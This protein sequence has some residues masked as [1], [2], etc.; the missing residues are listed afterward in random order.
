MLGSMTDLQNTPTPETTTDDSLEVQQRREKLADLRAQ[1]LQPFA[2]DF[3]PQNTSAALRDRFAA[4]E[5]ETLLQDYAEERFSLA[6]RLMGK[7][8]FGKLAFCVLED[9]SGRI[10]LSFAKNVLGEDDYTFFKKY[11]DVADVVGAHGSITKTDKGELTL[12]VH[13]FQ[14]LTKALRPLPDKWHGL[15]DIERRYRQRYV[16]LIVNPDVRA[17]FKTRTHIIRELRHYLETRDFMEVETPLLHHKAGGGAARP[18]ATHHNAL[19]LDLKLRIAPELYLKR[20]L[21][22]GF[23]RV[24]EIN[25]NFRNE[26]ISTRHNPEFT[27]METYVQ[28]WTLQNCMDLYEDMLKHIV[29]TIHG[30]LQVP[31]GEQT[32][33]F[34]QWRRLSMRDALLEMGG[35]TAADLA[36]MTSLSR[37][38]MQHNIEWEDW[39]DYGHLFA[40]VFEELC[41]DKLINPTFIYDHPVST[42]PLS[43][44]YDDQPDWTERA[45]LY[46][47][48]WEV[49]NMFSELND[50]ELQAAA[51][52]KQVEDAAKG[53]AEAM[54]YDHDYI[55]ALEHGM[56]P[57]GG[58]GL[59]VDRLVMLL[60]NSPSIRDVLLFPLMRPREG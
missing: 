38:A 60:T 5:K 40:H 37:F 42:S 48:G 22:G 59:G 14:L 44:P 27:M 58:T 26:G 9:T 21:V 55:T 30:T 13:S 18:F 15:E 16:D 2:N 50:P 49:A 45:E 35:A 51:F 6:G 3:V 29:Q 8:E 32:L 31:F 41:E 19:D 43:R 11:L 36:D 53:D 20:L 39:M 1:G 57:A 23:D 52:Q 7:R 33:D 46:I 17:T 34:N 54:P 10:Q 12:Q 25:R 24:F 4:L 56:P 28:Y 47:N